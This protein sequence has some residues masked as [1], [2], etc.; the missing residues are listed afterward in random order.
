MGPAGFFGSRKTGLAGRVVV[1]LKAEPRLQFPEMRFDL[2][3][4][5]VV[6]FPNVTEGMQADLSDLLHGQTACF[7]RGE[8]LQQCADSLA[9]KIAG[10][11][12]D[13]AEQAAFRVFGHD[14]IG[15]GQFFRAWNFVEKAC[16]QIRSFVLNDGKHDPCNAFGDRR[17][18]AGLQCDAI[19]DGLDGH[20]ILRDPGGVECPE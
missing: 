6:Q 4:E 17:V 13:P 7:Q 15:V 14:V 9:R 8:P 20:F 11:I 10:S 18:D 2:V 19:D 3:R 12:G 1:V 5:E 16:R